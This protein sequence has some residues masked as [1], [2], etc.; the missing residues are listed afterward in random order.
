MVSNR[1]KDSDKNAAKQAAEDVIAEPNK[2]GTSTPYDFEAKNLCIFGPFA[3][4]FRRYSE[5]EPALKHQQATVIGSGNSIDRVGGYVAK[6]RAVDVQVRSSPLRMI[7]GVLRRRTQ[8]ETESLVDG[9]PLGQAHIQLV[10]ARADNR[11]QG[12]VT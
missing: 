3:V 10:Y 7:Q 9:E 6:G 4:A 11:P 1:K 5:V 12:D 8:L 2:I